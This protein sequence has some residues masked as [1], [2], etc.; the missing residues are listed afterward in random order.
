VILGSV[1]GSSVGNLAIQQA[2]LENCS[3]SSTG[4]TAESVANWAERLSV[5]SLSNSPD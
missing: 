4:V 2:A 1:E 3:H 5:T